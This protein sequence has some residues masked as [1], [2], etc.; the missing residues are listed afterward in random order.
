MEELVSG[1]LLRLEVGDS[2]GRA[3]RS[4][5]LVFDEAP[6]GECL[7]EKETETESVTEAEAEAETKRHAPLQ[8]PHSLLR[9]RH[10]SLLLHLRTHSAVRSGE[11]RV[12]ACG[13]G[14]P[15]GWQC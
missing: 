8:S 6:L 10:S 14:T 4:A 15:R 7:E 1:A 3:V 9:F 11:R 13:Q 12:R 2:G 5:Q